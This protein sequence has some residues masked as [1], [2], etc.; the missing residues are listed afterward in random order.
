MRTDEAIRLSP[1]ILLVEDGNGIR[2]LPRY[3]LQKE[4]YSVLEA[5][6]GLE[7][8]YLAR[9]HRAPVDILVTEPELRFMSGTELSRE[10][11]EQWPGM[12]TVFVGG[13]VC[14]CHR[15]SGSVCLRKPVPSATL[16]W[17]IQVLLHRAAAAGQQLE[18]SQHK[19]IRVRAAKFET[20]P[21]RVL[22]PVI[23]AVLHR[24]GARALGS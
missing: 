14:T 24:S 20:A 19:R 2:R 17:T 9:T 4:G 7:A 8:M 1:T 23:P 10:L 21:V 13:D 11:T 18:Y 3:L 16:L 15:S 6:H 22:R 5:A 12:K